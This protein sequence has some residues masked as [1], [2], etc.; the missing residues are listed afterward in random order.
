MKN[1]T[2]TIEQALQNDHLEKTMILR[3]LVRA[4]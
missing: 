2:K 3:E 1:F 4:T